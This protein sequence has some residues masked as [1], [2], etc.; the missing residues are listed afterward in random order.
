VRTV[1]AASDTEALFSRAVMN[2][3]HTSTMLESNY[4]VPKKHLIQLHATGG[5]D[6]LRG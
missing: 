6:E 3:R 2:V 4:S 5:G 1:D